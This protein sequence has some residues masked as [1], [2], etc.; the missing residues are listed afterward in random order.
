MG[1]DLP[2]TP[3]HENRAVATTPAVAYVIDWKVSDQDG[4]I[5]QFSSTSISSHLTDLA[6]VTLAPGRVRLVSPS[7][8]LTPSQYQAGSLAAWLSQASLVS[9]PPTGIASSVPEVAGVVWGSGGYSGPEGAQLWRCW[10]VAPYAALDEARHVLSTLN[11]STPLSMIYSSL[12][13]QHERGQ[14]Y[15]GTTSMEMYIRAR[16]CCAARAEWLLQNAGREAAA[17]RLLNI[18]GSSS[19]DLERETA[20]GMTYES[21]F[22]QS[23]SSAGP[24][25]AELVRW[26]RDARGERDRRP[27]EVKSAC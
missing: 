13:Q 3:R 7:F 19:S 25:G 12:D 23:R 22:N 18:A 10:V 17:S 2:K 11:S 8:N 5:R 20:F 21:R 4:K 14:Q 24:T 15:T 6:N 9:P 16:G 26:R 27:V 1:S